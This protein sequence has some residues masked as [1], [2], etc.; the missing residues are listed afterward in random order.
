MSPSSARGLVIALSFVVLGLSAVATYV[1]FSL[2]A[3]LQ[4][5]PRGVLSLLTW[6]S[7]YYVGANL[8][9]WKGV[10]QISSS[11]PSRRA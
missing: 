2:L 8:I 7:A 9:F 10:V 5:L 3:P 11:Q 4:L 6:V 1:V